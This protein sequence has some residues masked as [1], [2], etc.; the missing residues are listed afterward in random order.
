VKALTENSVTQTDTERKRLIVADY[1]LNYIHMN[2]LAENDRLP[3]ENVLA[4]QFGVS[5]N[6]VRGAMEHLRAQGKVYSKQGKGFFI[7]KKQ[8]FVV[9]PQINN[10]G[11]S[12]TFQSPSYH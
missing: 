5:R 11:F 8:Q 4:A 7:A 9:Y 2:K 3:S 1:I 12:E 6:V 10:I